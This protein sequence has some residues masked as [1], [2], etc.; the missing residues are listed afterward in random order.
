[1]SNTSKHKYQASLIYS[2]K[3]KKKKSPQSIIPQINAILFNIHIS[4]HEIIVN[5]IDSRGKE[6]ITQ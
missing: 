1:M 3:K 6:K 4:L 2:C 5:N